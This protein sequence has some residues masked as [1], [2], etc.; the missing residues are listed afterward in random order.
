MTSTPDPMLG[1]VNRFLNIV[2]PNVPLPGG[3]QAARPQTPRPPASVVQ[4]E[5]AALVAQ[6]REIWGVPST[7]PNQP[8]NSSNGTVNGNGHSAGTGRRSNPDCDEVGAQHQIGGTGC[9]DVK[10]RLDHAM[11]E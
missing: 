6:W 1:P 4:T 2:I 11:H 8:G 5:A 3:K 7:T 10:M 9:V